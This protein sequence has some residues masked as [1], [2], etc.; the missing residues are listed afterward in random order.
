MGYRE[1]EQAETVVSFL[2]ERG[3]RIVVWGRSM[4][5]A[6]ALRFGKAS[7]I[8][9]DSAFKSFKSLCKQFAKAHTPCYVPNCLI[10]CLF[11]CV[12]CKIRSDVEQQGRYDVEMLDIA[13]AVK[14]ISL[15]TMVVFMSGD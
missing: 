1:A 6:T 14:G 5:A 12:F 10:S 15:G 9:A 13:E 11:P 4:G 2:R 7:V 3:Y 8:V